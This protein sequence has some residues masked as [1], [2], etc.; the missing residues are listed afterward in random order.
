MSEAI[1]R[2]ALSDGNSSLPAEA[3]MAEASRPATVGQ[4]L[5]AAREARGA[6]VDDVAEVLRFS[7]RQIEYIESD[8]YAAL[9]GATLVRGFIRG[10]AKFLQLDPQALIAQLD[11]AVPPETSD[12]RP[13]SSI[14]AASE[15]VGVANVRRI[16]GVA[17]LLLVGLV[18]L[19]LFIQSD[20]EL[21]NRPTEPIAAP[22][23]GPDTTVGSVAQSPAVPDSA[24][25]L[26]PV[27]P[28]VSADANPGEAVA[29]VQAAVAPSGLQID[30][31]DLSWVEIRDAAQ[32][33]ILVGEY[34]K[35]TH[36]QVDGKAPFSLWI[37]RA[38]AVRVS[39]Q[40]RALDLRA[41]SRED[42][43]RLTIE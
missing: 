5:R 8:N 29:V 21:T 7:V 40:G 23:P 19:Y 14:G 35:G 39:Y 36:K 18:G 11:A 43:A 26:E 4:I 33:V 12:V 38:S 30:F 22:V 37:G 41:T 24:A 20:Q 1:V 42:V 16:G 28:D 6:T 31:D 10:Y 27:V 32:Q 15:N 17:G 25:P 2:D 3:S 9:P 13:P 34:P